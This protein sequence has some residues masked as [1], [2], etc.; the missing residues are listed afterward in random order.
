GDRACTLHY[1]ANNQ[2]LSADAYVLID[3]GAEVAHYAADVT[4]TYSQGKP[5]SKQ[6]LIWQAVREA[7]AYGLSLMQPGRTLRENEADMVTFL[8][9]KL[10]Q[11]GYISTESDVSATRQYYSHGLSHF[12][13]LDVH[14]VG[15]YQRPLEPGMVLTVEPGLYVPKERVGV[16]I[17]DTIVITEDGHRNLSQDC[18]YGDEA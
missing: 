14:D 6:Q 4:R 18:T 11:L 1:I 12:V 5:G 7:H 13:G 15:D 17:E 8:G 2:P 9:K 10:K 3:A 16:R